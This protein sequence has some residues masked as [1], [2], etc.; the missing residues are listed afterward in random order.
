MKN[1]ETKV[2]TPLFPTYSTIRHLLRVFQGF[3]KSDVTAMV[4]D[5]R[6]QTGTPQNP[7]D[8]SDPDTW[9][10]ERLTGTSRELANR[11]WEDSAHEV[12]P[13][14]IYGGYLFINT[15]DLLDEVAGEYRANENTEA[16]LNGER[17]LMR[18]I[19]DT[20]GIGELLSILTTKSRASRSDLVPE[21]R[22]FLHEYSKYGT[23]STIKDTL[24]RRLVN[25]VD[26]GYVDREGNTYIIND[27]GVQYA[28]EFEQEGMID[29]RR[30]V[31]RAIQSYNNEQTTALR[32]KLSTMDPFQFEHLA[33]D[34]LE[35]MG[36]EDVEVT[37]QRGDKGVDVVATVQYGITTIREVV[38]VKRHKRAINRPKVDQLRGA[39]PYH[40]AIRGTIITLGR[41][42]SGCEE[43]ALYQGAAPITL[44]DGDRLIE[45]L[46]EHEV[47][48][49]KKPAQL[50]DID[51]N[52]F[53]VEN[54][55]LTE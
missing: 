16:F 7:V 29:P 39:L 2:R 24:R 14:H 6:N 54:D 1:E 28:A 33:K 26:R 37:K 11:I 35:S 17:D 49:L 9:I 22:Q 36:Y 8:W 20:E 3:Q 53:D 32:E 40:D 21:W 15:F 27:K 48:V 46:I 43:A 10:D 38:Q 34:L 18:S 5:I 44:I 45:L 25:L 55:A 12:N 30:D 51:T 13:R 19:D 47:G 31:L 42:S 41:F 52:Y 50:F 23:P 4:Q